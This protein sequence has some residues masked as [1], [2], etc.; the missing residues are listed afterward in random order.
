VYTYLD[1]ANGRF[2]IE[3]SNLTHANTDS[4]ET[5]Q[6]IIY[7]PC[8]YSTP[9]GD[10]EI[11]FQ[12]NHI[13]NNDYVE[14]P[15]SDPETYS[16]V[17]IENWQENIGLQYEYNNLYPAGAAALAN[18]RAIR[19]TTRRFDLPPASYPSESHTP[20]SITMTCPPGGM[21]SSQVI[22]SNSG[23][24]GLGY[25]LTAA[26]L[27]YL[28]NSVNPEP[29]VT[30]ALPAPVQS[31][32]LPK[33]EEIYKPNPPMT[34]NQGG[35]DAFGHYWIDSD[36]SG[37][38]TFNWVDISGVGTAITLNDDNNNGPFSLGFTFPYF[39]TNY[40]SLY[41]SSNGM[42]TFSSDV[43]PS[44]NTAIPSTSTPNN[45][46][47]AWWDDIDPPH[48]GAVRY[49]A[50]AA[51]HRFIVS[52]DSVAY[53]YSSTPGYTGA[54]TFQIILYE[55]GHFVMQYKSMNPG[56]YSTG[57]NG[58][59]IGFEN[60]GGTDGLQI[61]YNAAYMHNNLAI[62]VTVPPPPPTTLTLSPVQES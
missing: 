62:Q 6:M 11:V 57:L 49:Y 59:T 54:L 37:G 32:N 60:A 46:I 8:Q 34:T 2:I 23:A 39:G 4:I 44:N 9:T 35:P 56:S 16:S 21:T 25:T 29:P 30:D 5:F 41:V 42:I 33:T 53:Y 55:D 40:T 18:G 13:V 26:S 43:A 1:G 38:P 31:P 10:C 58:A 36:E 51:N 19:F 7:D 48:Q 24:C 3:W 61:C 50:D 12:Y 47:A 27:G 45:Y 52:Y 17:G 20:S 28:R 14:D 22:I 15:Y